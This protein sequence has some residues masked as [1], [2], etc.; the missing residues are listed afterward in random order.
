MPEI[1]LASQD[2]LLEVQDTLE[3]VD[4]MVDDIAE[5]IS[6][7][8][9]ANVSSRASQTDM[10]IVKTDV[11]TVKTSSAAI[12]ATTEGIETLLGVANPT[13]AET[14]T[15]MGYLKTL[16]EKASSGGDNV[17]TYA[18]IIAANQTSE[19]VWLAITLA[20]AEGITGA[21]MEKAY[22]LNNANLRELPTWYDVAGLTLALGGNDLRN[23]KLFM[24]QFFIFKTSV[25][26]FIATHFSIA[27]LDARA[28][29]LDVIT[30]SQAMAN[31]VCGN[32]NMRTLIAANKTAWMPIFTHTN[33]RGFSL[34][35]TAVLAFYTEIGKNREA[36]RYIANSKD[37][38]DSMNANA[39]ARQAVNGLVAGL[40]SLGIL[41]TH[42]LGVIGI[43][44]ITPV[45]PLSPNTLAIGVMNSLPMLFLG[46]SGNLAALEFQSQGTTAMSVAAGGSNVIMR[47]IGFTLKP[48]TQVAAGN[49]ARWVVISDLSE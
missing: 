23:S 48:S 4:V 47:G 11:A 32:A 26:R 39:T 19:S 38:M 20:D 33:A 31:G 30:G 15:V 1:K 40:T 14:A 7:K 34:N 17:S 37:V 25:G 10:T 22:G 36:V 3:A 42:T 24:E 2:T 9:D 45:L 6:G 28:T 5:E 18:Q 13:T 27:G 41:K 12:K 35:G 43:N 16:D 8:F 46:I 44:N 21:V 29:W 49:V